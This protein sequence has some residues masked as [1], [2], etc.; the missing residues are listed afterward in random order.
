MA[1]SKQ[2]NNSLRDD[3]LVQRIVDTLRSEY[4]VPDVSAKVFI[5]LD[6]MLTLV[7]EPTYRAI[8]ESFRSNIDGLIETVAFPFIMASNHALEEQYDSVRKK[9]Y[10]D[11]TATAIKVMT[12]SDAEIIS[13]TG[14]E[15]TAYVNSPEG[16]YEHLTRVKSVLDMT[17]ANVCHVRDTL[18]LQGAVLAWSALEVFAYDFLEAYLNRH[19]EACGDLFK[20]HKTK[21]DFNLSDATLLNHLQGNAY[22]LSALMGTI[23]VREKKR[24]SFDSIQNA[25]RVL[26]KDKS[27]FENEDLAKAIL[28]LEKQRNLIVHKECQDRC[29]I[30]CT[31]EWNRSNR[32]P[33]GVNFSEF[34]RPC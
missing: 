19:S 29:Q 20:D 30:Q 15:F 32:R 25:Y 17:Y 21:S 26:F 24:L 16:R 13:K 10:G 6:P 27:P 11:M 8:G 14:K 23:I 31:D 9:V 28:L 18:L 3:P 2:K 7:H 1:D 34:A 12:I 33:L 5:G 4:F 22:N